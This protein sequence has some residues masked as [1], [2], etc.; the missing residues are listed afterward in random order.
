MSNNKFLL[1]VIGL[2]IVILFINNIL[3]DKIAD[4]VIKKLQKDYSPSP[5]AAAE[6]N[7]DKIDINKIKK[8]NWNN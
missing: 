3:V 2:G 5:Y 4:H 6:V 1:I 7:P 8:Q